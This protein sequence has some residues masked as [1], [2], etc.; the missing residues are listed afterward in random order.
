MCIPLNLER[1]L[2]GA[3]L[4]VK[5]D[6]DTGRPTC[7]GRPDTVCRYPMAMSN[8]FRRGDARRIVIVDPGSV[9]GDQ[10]ATGAPVEADPLTP[11]KSE[12]ETDA[13]CYSARRNIMRAA[14]GRKE[15]V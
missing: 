15:I 13:S 12:M 11:H 7:A 10:S 2:Y 1:K 6:L 9:A 3:S 8:R 4:L 5:I 14:E